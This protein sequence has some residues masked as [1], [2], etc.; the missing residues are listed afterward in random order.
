MADFQDSLLPIFI[1]ETEEGLALIQNLISSGKATSISDEILEEARRAA[2][3]IKGTAGLVK[4]MHS[5]A[6]AKTIE[7]FLDSFNDAKDDFTD[8]D[9]EKIRGWHAQLIELLQLARNG[10]PE[11]PID[12]GHDGTSTNF[13]IAQDTDEV[14]GYSDDLIDDFA[15]PFMMKLHQ[16]SDAVDEMVKPICCRFYLGGRQYYIPIEDVVEIS[17]DVEMTFPPYAPAY[18]SGLISLR[19]DVIPVIDLAAL[20]QRPLTLPN[21][22]FLVIARCGSDL[23]AFMSDMLPN[24]NIKTAGH[25]IDMCNFLEQHS[26][27]AS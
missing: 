26:V 15:L 19:G 9:M 17:M 7:E 4:R 14:E 1:E 12:E 23:M 18:I 11:P 3:T 27:K 20:E 25:K 22:V 10:K 16:A 5:S 24:L 13:I 6:I 21:S 2:H 8:S